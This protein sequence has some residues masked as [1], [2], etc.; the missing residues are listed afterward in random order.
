MATSLLSA[1]PLSVY[2]VK[3][4]DATTLDVLAQAAEA[5]EDEIRW[6]NPEL[7]RG[8]TPPGEI[9]E[10]RV[11]EGQGEIFTLNYAA[12]PQGERMTVVEHS[13]EHGETLSHISV[14]YGISVRDLRAANPK[15]TASLFRVGMRLT[16]PILINR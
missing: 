9:Y 12:I 8:F 7:F 6:L 10:L 13:V 5:E 2:H 3:V 16:V 14:K 15:G 1:P 4:P 11:P